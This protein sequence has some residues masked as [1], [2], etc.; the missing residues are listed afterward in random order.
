MMHTGNEEICAR[1]TAAANDIEGLRVNI[2]M[3][4]TCSVSH[5]FVCASCLDSLVREAIKP[6][7]DHNTAN[8]RRMSDG[9][10]HCPHCIS[11]LPRVLCDFPDPHLAKALPASLFD[12]YLRARMQLLEDRMGCELEAQMQQRLAQVT[13]QTPTHPCM[14]AWCIMHHASCIIH[15]CVPLFWACTNDVRRV[16]K[17]QIRHVYM[18]VHMRG[19]SPQMCI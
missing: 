9:K 8:L 3:G 11:Q 14:H 17:M 13:T 7:G 15:H 18:Y 5:H 16:Y 19:Y 10:I 2:N 1:L 4:V 12:A 6:G